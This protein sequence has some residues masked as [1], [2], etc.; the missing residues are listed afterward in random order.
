MLLNVMERDWRVRD[1]SNCDL[2]LLPEVFSWPKLCSQSEAI[3]RLAFMGTLEDSVVKDALSKTPR[4]IHSLPLS[5]R[6][7]NI[8]SSA[9]KLPWWI[10]LEKPNSLLPGLFETGHIFQ[11]IGIETNDS[12]L[13]V[14]PR[15][16]WW[17]EI[18]LHM[19]VK[20][21][22]ILEIDDVRREVLQN[23][24]ES[25]RLDIV[26][27][28]LN[29]DIEW[30]GLEYIDNKND[31]LLDK[32]IITGGLTT[33]PTN[34]LSKID[35]N[36]QIW[37]PIGSNNSTVL[38]KITKEEFGEVRCQHITLWNVDMLDRY[39]ENILCGS[40]VFERNIIKNSIEESPE[41]TR[42][43]WLHA[44]DNPIRDRLG[45]ES[46]L[47][48]IKEVWNTSDILLETDNISLK[49]S[50]AKDLFKMGHVLQKIGVF[51]IAAEHHG[52]SYLLSPSAEAACYLG[53]TYSIDN[54]DSLAWQRK[55][56]ETDPNFGEA[57][58]EIGEI[59]MKKDD[60]KNAV[61]W[62]REA[63]ASK[64]YSKRWVAYTNLTRSQIELEQD[65]SAFF[66]AQ[67][68]V[69]LFPENKELTELLFYLGED[70]V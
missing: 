30:C 64:N 60:V 59:L 67:K 1:I 14:G 18:I 42:E 40:S 55:A 24:W 21:I 48:I 54:Q 34:L 51:R 3:E 45:P 29:C 41:A 31:I 47:E 8:E 36:G 2:E 37:A 62:F 12:I 43:A 13:L 56:I 53:M 23:R 5:I 28:A 20:K 69:E 32:V 19:G 6:I 49:D 22:T 46:L 50:I 66:T 38:Q 11:M 65:I 27:K 17:T 52:M 61:N 7:E 15:G 44:N 70:L 39:S 58:N 57:W 63:I 16:N 26:A 33:I 4:E 25:L 10:D 68:A 35:M 9:L